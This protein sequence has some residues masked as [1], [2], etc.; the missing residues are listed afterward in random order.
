L[1]RRRAGIHPETTRAPPRLFA[2]R[3]WVLPSG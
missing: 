2:Q 1:L 3:E